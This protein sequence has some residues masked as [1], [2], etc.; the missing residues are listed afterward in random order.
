MRR[1]LL[2]LAVLMGVGGPARAE[3]SP[4]DRAAIAAVIAE[5]LQAFRL[6]D[7]PRAFS[8]ASPGIQGMFGTPE[9]FLDMVRRAYPPV[10]RSTQ[11]EFTTLTDEGEVV[12]QVELFHDGQWHTA[13]YSMERSAD[14]WRISGCALVRSARVGA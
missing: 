8:F 14:G 9:N 1:A 5:Q 10:H 11:G 4:A 2:V 7:A 12:Q 3:V 6:D 13:L